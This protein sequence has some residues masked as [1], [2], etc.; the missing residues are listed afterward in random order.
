MANEP[1]DSPEAVEELRRH[2]FD[3]L[4][5]QAWFDALDG[6]VED[7]TIIRMETVR[8]E[9]PVVMWV[10]LEVQIDS[11][12]II[13]QTVL[14]LAPQVPDSVR[15]AAVIGEVPTSGDSLMVYDALAD[16]ESADAFV[17]HVSAGVGSGTAVS[18][19]DAPW[20]TSI[21]LGQQ[22]ELT[23]YRRVEAGAHPDVELT[24][25]LAEAGMGMVRP[26][27]AVWRKNHYDLAAVRRAVRRGTPGIEVARESVDELLSRRCQPRENPLDVVESITDLGR[28]IAEVHVE[29]ADRLG[30]SLSDGQKLVEQLV[31]R[32]PRQLSQAA[33]DRIAESYRRLGFADDLGLFIRVHGNLELHTVE[34]IRNGWVLSGFGCDPASSLMHE[35]LPMSPLSDLAGLLHGFQTVAAEAL[36]QVVAGRARERGGPDEPDF[37]EQGARRELTVLAEAWEERSVD[38]LISGYTSYDPVHRLL[39]VERISRDALLTLFELELSVRDAVRSMS[40]GPDILRIPVERVEGLSVGEVRLRW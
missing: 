29:L 25:L 1:I 32:L 17:A 5:R 39:P 8:R 21:A 26:P 20:V 34:R 28:S 9:W 16:P 13:V 19:T 35:R 4:P 11:A 30:S 22:W 15:D 18:S 23:L 3:W 2:L 10:P 6:E 40:R 31:A 36:A 24:G 37:H 33:V 12:P 38:A 27:A 14:A 7:I